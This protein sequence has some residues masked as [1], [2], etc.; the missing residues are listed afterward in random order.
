MKILFIGDIYGKSGRLALEKY[1][2]LIKEK[3]DVDLTILNGENSTHGKGLNVKNYN[4]I[5]NAGVDFITLGNHFLDNEEIS[6]IL[7]KEENVVR[8]LNLARFNEGLGTRV[9]N[10]KGIDVRITN[11]I[12]RVYV[13]A[14]KFTI[15]NPFDALDGVVAAAQEKIHIVDIHA[16]ATGEKKSFAKY[17]DGRVSAILGTH[18]HVQTVDNQVFSKGTAY[19]SDV[20]Y[21]GAYD[22]VL[23]VLNK[24]AIAFSKDQ[25]FSMNEPCESKELEFSA[26][27]LDIDE[28][29]G[30]TISIKR[31]Y[32]TPQKQELKLLD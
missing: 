7:K 8:P 16:E 31:I 28:E 5:K 13:N 19:I 6:L 30:K 32:L 27:Y 11:I 15:T 9:I 12:G 20:G 18:T 4:Y 26:V 23:G 21:C 2:P 1:L 3:Y 29:T 17:F 10:V 25:D 14:K 24:H 22:S